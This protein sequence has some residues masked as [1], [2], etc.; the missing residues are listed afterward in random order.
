MHKQKVYDINIGVQDQLNEKSTFQA[1]QQKKKMLLK[2]KQKN[3]SPTAAS[4]ANPHAYACLR[5]K[6]RIL[7][8]VGRG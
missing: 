1:R 3:R 5:E 8:S 7:E 2:K 4:T 6:P